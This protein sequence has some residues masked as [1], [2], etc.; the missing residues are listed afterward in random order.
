MKKAICTISYLSTSISATPNHALIPTNISRFRVSQTLQIQS[1]NFLILIKFTYRNSND[2]LC[3]SR[4][5]D[6][7]SE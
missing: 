4:S 5:T 3:H 7:L 1:S 2:F 6:C